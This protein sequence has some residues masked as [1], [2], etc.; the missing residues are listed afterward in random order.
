MFE[1]VWHSLG[2]AAMQDE[3]WTEAIRAFTKVVALDSENGN[4]WNNLAAIQI[5]LGQ[6]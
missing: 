6:K 2:C 4:A 5:K 3:D 1:N